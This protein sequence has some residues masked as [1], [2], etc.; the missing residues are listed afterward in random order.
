MAINHYMSS[1]ELLQP[2]IFSFFVALVFELCI[3]L[4][5]N[6]SQ[7][8]HLLKKCE[9]ATHALQKCSAVLPLPA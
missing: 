7:E 9:M 5:K 2:G 3:H 6:T 8:S 1:T 4:S